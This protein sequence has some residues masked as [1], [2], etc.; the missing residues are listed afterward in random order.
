MG[1]PERRKRI[2]LAALKLLPR[3]SLQDAKNQFSKLVAVVTEA[4]TPQL[5]TR[6]G[7]DAVVVLLASD[8]E[9]LLRGS[10][11]RRGGTARFLAASPLRTVTLEIDRPA[12]RGRDPEL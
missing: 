4:G 7:E 1:A 9:R 2:P 12:D 11:R 5:V 8:Y 3:W 10:K 6:H